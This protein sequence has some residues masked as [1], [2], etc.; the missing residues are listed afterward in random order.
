MFSSNKILYCS[1]IYFCVPL[2]ATY[3]YKNKF[4]CS[5]F[6]FAYNLFINNNTCSLD[7]YSSNLQT[8][9]VLFTRNAS[10]HKTDWIHTTRCLFSLAIL[11]AQV[12]SLMKVLEVECSGFRFVNNYIT[13]SLLLSYFLLIACCCVRLLD[14]PL[15]SH[16]VI[17][18]LFVRKLVNDLKNIS[19]HSCRHVSCVCHYLPSQ[20]DLLVL[21][22]ENI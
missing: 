12:I 13:I 9:T 20:Y 14:Y 11:Y 4:N 18:G 15:L 7:L 5:L 8:T 6:F 10:S 19:C 16:T 1:H 2:F 22:M 21:L 3:W 17:D